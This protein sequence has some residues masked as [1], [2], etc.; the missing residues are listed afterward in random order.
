MRGLQGW[1]R[2]RFLGWSVAFGGAEEIQET[3]FYQAQPVS[4]APLGLRGT[5]VLHQPLE[6]VLP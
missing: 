4:F 2:N 5:G 6:S 3:A 1:Y